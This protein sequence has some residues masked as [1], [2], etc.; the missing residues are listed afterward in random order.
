MEE[1]LSTVNDIY[2]TKLPH[3]AKS[4]IC[5]CGATNV[6]GEPV[7][8]SAADRAIMSL[9]CRRSI[10]FDDAAVNEVDQMRMD[11]ARRGVP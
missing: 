6:A 4:W 2:V 5:C 1:T 9:N 7:P 8:G 10:A 11:R 3:Y